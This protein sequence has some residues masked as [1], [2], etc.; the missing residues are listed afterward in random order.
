[1]T[2]LAAIAQEAFT[3]V[4]A[5]VTDVVHDVTITRVAQ[6]AYNATTGAYSETETTTEG[7]GVMDGVNP[8][9]DI[10]PAHIR[11][12]KDQLWLVRG[13]SDIREGDK[14][15]SGGNEYTVAAARDILGAGSLWYLV[16]Q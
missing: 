2:T 10:F 5:Q 16:A 13:V 1:M 15:A 14:L 8:V 7:Q 9:K 3:K 6:G 12:P 4:A 11:G